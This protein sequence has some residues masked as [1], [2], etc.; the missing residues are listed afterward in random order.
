MQIRKE[1]KNTKVSSSTRVA[2][3]YKKKKNEDN[4]EIKNPF[5]AENSFLF[6]FIPFP[7]PRITIFKRT[8]GVLIIHG[9]NIDNLII[10]AMRVVVIHSL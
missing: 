4:T 6:I 9:I 10:I 1:E 7:L 8:T 5:I 2:H 3:C